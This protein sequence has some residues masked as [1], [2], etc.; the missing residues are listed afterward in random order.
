[1][2]EYIPGTI[3]DGLF[4]CRQGDLRA[5]MTVT[6]STTYPVTGGITVEAITT[7]DPELLDYCGRILEFLR[8]DGLCDVE[9]KKDERDGTYKLL[10]INPRIWGALE[11][12]L[13]AGIDFVEKSCELAVT[14]DTAV[15][16]DYRVGL[17]H[18]ILQRELMAIHQDKGHRWQRIRRLTGLFDRDTVYGIDLTDWKPELAQLVATIRFFTRKRNLLLPAGRSFSVEECRRLAAVET[19]DALAIAERAVPAQFGPRSH[20]PTR[21]ARVRAA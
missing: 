9:V 10:E 15:Q 6:R 7:R 17:K 8:Y 21:P 14:G 4:A 16:M 20:G 13:C 5:A 3:H 11:L 19:E 12:S 1:M 2:Q 18:W